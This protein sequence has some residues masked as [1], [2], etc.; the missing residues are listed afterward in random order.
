MERMETQNERRERMKKKVLLVIGLVGVLTLTGCSY[1]EEYIP[2][3]TEIYVMNVDD[4]MKTFT[5]E[6][7]VLDVPNENFK[8]VC[9]YDTG[10]YG[11]DKWRV[12]DSKSISMTVSTKD[13]PERYDVYIDHVHADI[14]LASSKPMINGIIQDSMDDSVH[15]ERERGFCIGNETTYNNIFAIEGYTEQFYQLWGYAFSDYGMMQ[16]TYER[17]T[18]NNIIKLG[19]YG[20]KLQIVYDLAIKAPDEA[21]YHFV[22][23]LS[24]MVIPISQDTSQ[25]TKTVNYL[26]GE[27]R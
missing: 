9:K 12:T 2:E 1:T 24:E 5:V 16:S 27:D 21:D 25:N 4:N 10:R 23:V 8:L 3:D 13:L 17:L 18:E 19:T 14:S 15:S 7:Q 6:P 26:T 11:F 22:S 20:E